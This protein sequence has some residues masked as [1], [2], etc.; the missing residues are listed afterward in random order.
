[1]ICSLDFSM[2]VSGR[3]SGHYIIDTDKGEWTECWAYA[4]SVSD[5]ESDSIYHDNNFFF[6]QGIVI[7]S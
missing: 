2:G 6:V 3:K 7:Y 1:M 4:G 5:S